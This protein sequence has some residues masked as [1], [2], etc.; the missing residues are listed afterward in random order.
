MEER[1]R[2]REGLMLN[3]FRSGERM[4]DRKARK[5]ENNDENKLMFIFF[6]SAFYFY[7]TNLINSTLV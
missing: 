3:R 2:E 5:T 1:E 6:G 7:F 4:S